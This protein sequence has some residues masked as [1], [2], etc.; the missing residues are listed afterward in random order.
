MVV[1][2]LVFLREDRDLVALLAAR[3]SRRG[4]AAGSTSNLSETSL[5]IKSRWR[6]PC[7]TYL[8]SCLPQWY[9]VCSS[10]AVI[11]RNMSEISLKITL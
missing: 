11:T 6:S 2:V 7:C 3:L 4:V 5:E 1:G 9:C 10:P 8:R